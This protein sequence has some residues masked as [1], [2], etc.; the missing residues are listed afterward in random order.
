MYRMLTMTSISF[1]DENSGF[2]VGISHG[3][4]YLPAQPEPRPEPLSTVPFP[5]D[6]DFVSRD[7]LFNQI[8]NKTSVGG[9]KI[10]LVGLGGVG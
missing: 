4:I 5:H 6:P 2:Q 9:S 10:V 3:P 8:D 7:A 1:G